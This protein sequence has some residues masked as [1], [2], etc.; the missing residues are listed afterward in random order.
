MVV[1]P[2]NHGVFLFWLSRDQKTELMSFRVA[3]LYLELDIG[4]FLAIQRESFARIYQHHSQ[5]QDDKPIC[6]VR[7][8]GFALIECP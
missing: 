4:K 3:V 6:A 7:H 8:S 2:V 5:N 1:L